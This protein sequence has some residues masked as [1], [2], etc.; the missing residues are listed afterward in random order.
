[1]KRLSL[2]LALILLLLL[3]G[4]AAA[5]K[6]QAEDTGL[7][8]AGKV[9]CLSPSVRFTEETL[10]QKEILQADS[11]SFFSTTVL[12]L[13]ALMDGDG[14]SFL[15][16]QPVAEFYANRTKEL[17][18]ETL[19]HTC[20]LKML[21]TADDTALLERLNTALSDLK[22]DGTLDNLYR[23]WVTDLSAGGRPEDAE[24][25]PV[26]PTYTD[27]DAPLIR[28]GICGSLP[29]VDYVSSEGQASGYST[30]L[31]AAIAEK[32]QANVEFVQ[33]LPDAKVSA[34]LSNKIDV[35]FWHFLDIPANCAATEAYASC[36]AALLTV[37]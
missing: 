14:D 19:S 2:I 20:D 4:C 17:T 24:Q 29:L 21:L 36:P 3:A 33:I 11:L 27:A 10:A 34:L 35:Y 8:S 25:Q 32:L 26:L 13:N 5:P 16:L 23:T 12:G 18:A 37:K 31:M 22:A 1:M 30:A 9:L 6:E 28:V 15:T 7:V